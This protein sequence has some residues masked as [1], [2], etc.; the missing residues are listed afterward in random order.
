MLS[1]SSTTRMRCFSGLEMRHRPCV[2]TSRF[3]H[4]GFCHS[5]NSQIWSKLTSSE[6]EQRVVVRAFE[7]RRLTGLTCD[8]NGDTITF[9]VPF[10]PFSSSFVLHFLKLPQVG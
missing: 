9:K 10:Q 1:S 6:C 4:K 5:R 2:R 3:S 7:M 8:T